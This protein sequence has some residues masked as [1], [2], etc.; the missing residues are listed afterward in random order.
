MSPDELNRRIEALCEE[1]GLTFKVWEILPWWVT[2]DEVNPYPKTTGGYE[3]F[4]KAQKLRR[5]L[6]AEIMAA[7]K[8]KRARS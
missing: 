5:Q 4:P 6:V 3:S 8:A 2:E 7:E 1:K